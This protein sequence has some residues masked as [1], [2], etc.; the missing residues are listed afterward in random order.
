[1][2]EHDA[3]RGQWV[4][5]F[6]F[7]YFYLVA[8]ARALLRLTVDDSRI[9][10]ASLIQFLPAP[11]AWEDLPSLIAAPLLQRL[12]VLGFMYA[13]LMSFGMGHLVQPISQTPSSEILASQATSALNV[14][15]DGSKGRQHHPIDSIVFDTFDL[16][17][18]Y[19]A[20]PLLYSFDRNV[21]GQTSVSSVNC[22]CPDALLWVRN[23]LLL[24]GEEKA[25]SHLLAVAQAELLRKM[26][27]CWSSQL[28]GDCLYQ[29]GMSIRVS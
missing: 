3:S 1:M 27:T 2:H 17:R 20:Q 12:P 14:K 19:S 23:A 16:L 5:F 9:M 18:L 8:E 25:E 15:F 6:L 11:A 7:I 28:F 22:H 4:L 13:R 24:K 10:I 21:E 26:T 29:L